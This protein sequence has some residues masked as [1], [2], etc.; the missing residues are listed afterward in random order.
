MK[1]YFM[2]FLAAAAAMV[3]CHKEPVQGPQPDQPQY[4]DAREVTIEA[5]TLSKTVLAGDKVMWEGGD[6]IALIFHHSTDAPHVNKTFANEE[7]EKKSERAI[8]RGFVPN[9]VTVDNGYNDLG[10]AVYPKTA[11]L[12]NGI[13]SHTLPAEQEA[14]ADG[15]FAS[16]LNLSSAALALSEMG[17][18]G[19]TKTD[20]RSALSILRLNLTSDIRSVTLTGTAPLAGTAPLH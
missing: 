9:S 19:S 10:F 17:E 4:E 15:S 5:G 20:F 8:F 1:R 6:E 7:K 13:F 18:G 12:E 14:L 2:I 16:G 11:I 3:S